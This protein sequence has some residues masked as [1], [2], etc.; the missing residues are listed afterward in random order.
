[1]PQSDFGNGRKRWSMRGVWDRKKGFPR[2]WGLRGEP[3]WGYR[4]VPSRKQTAQK[5]NHSVPIPLERV[6][7]FSP[8]SAHRSVFQAM[9]AEQRMRT[10]G[11]DKKA[12]SKKGTEYLLSRWEL[13]TREV[14]SPL[15][16][17]LK[18]KQVFHPQKKIPQNLFPKNQPRQISSL[19]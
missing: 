17:G 5:K 1:M 6:S 10:P 2:D 12:G 15:G 14:G 9:M 11:V 8:R 7:P 18:T 13:A 4:T 3:Q 19:C 16:R